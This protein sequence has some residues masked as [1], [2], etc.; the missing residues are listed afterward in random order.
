ME[1]EPGQSLDEKAFAKEFKVSRTP[2]REALLKLKHEKLVDIIPRGGIFVKRID[3][4]ELRDVFHI[5]ILVEGEVAKIAAANKTQ[6]HLMEIQKLREECKK[7]NNISNPKELI[8]VDIALRDILYRAANSSILSEI[9]DYLY[10]QTLRVWYLVFNKTCFSVEV[11]LQL[12]EIDIVLEFLKKGDP[13][14]AEKGG[15]DIVINYLN[16]ISK[17]FR[18]LY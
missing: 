8:Q 17:Y 6:D 10:Y 2:V 3:F 5:R 12:K 14:F 18:T 4:Q 16:R 1:L 11:E 13:T 7:M 15:K 9:S